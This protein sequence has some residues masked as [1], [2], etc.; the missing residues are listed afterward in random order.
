MGFK[1][2]MGSMK[3]KM[4]MKSR[5]RSKKRSKTLK[6]KT[7]LLVDLGSKMLLARTR[8]PTKTKTP[9]RKKNPCKL[10][11]LRTTFTNRR[12]SR[13]NSTKCPRASL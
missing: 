5:T 1:E 6:R 3:N 9:K 2:M 10:T 13:T 4:A 11:S 7:L 12:A 8:M